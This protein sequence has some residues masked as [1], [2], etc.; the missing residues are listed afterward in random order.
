MS[1]STPPDQEGKGHSTIYRECMDSTSNDQ[2]MDNG[3]AYE[4]FEPEN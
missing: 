3:M 4:G 2:N 1:K